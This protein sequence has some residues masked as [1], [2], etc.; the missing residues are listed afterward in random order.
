MRLTRDELIM[1]KIYRLAREYCPDR[2]TNALSVGRS[3]SRERQTL[4]AEDRKILKDFHL[5]L[6]EANVE[7]RSK[8][9]HPIPR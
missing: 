3:P 7:T 6:F 8:H 1:V 9:Q 4:G 2:P 5:K